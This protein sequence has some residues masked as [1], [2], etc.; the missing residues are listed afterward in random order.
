MYI[1]K[2]I[3]NVN[4]NVQC[5]YWLSKLLYLYNNILYIYSSIELQQ[6]KEKDWNVY[7]SMDVW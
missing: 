1:Y 5:I 7:M 6:Q 4:S 2:Y 3:Q